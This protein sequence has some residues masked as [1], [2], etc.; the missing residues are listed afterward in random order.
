MNDLRCACGADNRPTATF[1]GGCGARLAATCHVCGRDLPESNRFCDGCGAPRP[2]GLSYTSAHLQDEVLVSRSAIEG[3]RRVLT[4]L[5]ADVAGFSAIAR[6]LG[7][8]AAHTFME[9]CFQTLLPCVHRY[10]GTVNQFTGDGVMALFGAPVAHEDHA[11][12]ALRAALAIRDELSRYDAETQRQ[13]QAPCQ[14]R[15]G[16]NTGV[17]VVGRIGDNVRMD[18][19]A[20]GDTTNLAAR[21]Q[22][23]AP[24][25]AIW[26][27]ESTRRL[28][29][30]Q[31]AWERLAPETVRGQDEPVQAYALVSQHAT[32]PSK[33][34]ETG[35]HGPTPL[36]GRDPEL[37][38]LEAAWAEARLGR[39]RV[40]SV[41]GEAGMGKT[42]L[43]HEFRRKLAAGP[44][45]T[46]CQG[47]CFD[48]G[49]TS[50]YLPF[51]EL[52]KGMFRLHDVR[53]ETEAVRRVSEGVAELGLEAGVTAALL[54]ILS[55]PVSDAGFRALPANL[56]RERTVKALRALV[57]AMAARQ[58]LV[59]V[60]EDLHWIDEA[61]QE[62]VNGL[63][64][65]A[66]GLS[67]LLVL[68]FRP[69]YMNHWE[70]QKHHRRI[71]LSPLPSLTSAEMVRAVLTRSHATWV[72]LAR[73]S[74][75][76]SSE[77]VR[78]L[79][80]AKRVPAALEQLVVQT[81]DGNPL[82][83]EELVLSLL[84][85]G[86]LAGQDDDWVLTTPEGSK[87]PDTLQGL[88][89]ARVD[90][91]DDNLKETLRMASVI[92]RVFS[93]PIL[94][95]AAGAGPELEAALAQLEAL[96]LI[97]RQVDARPGTY[98]FKHALSQE[99]I[100][101][102]ILSSRRKIFHQK[103]G[104]AI[105]SLEADRLNEHCELLAFH[106]ENSTDLD[107][108]VEYLHQANRKAIGVSAMKDAQGYYDRAV[109]LFDL[110]PTDRRNQQRK[111][112][113]VLDQVFVAL[114]LFKYREYHELLKEHAALPEISGDRRTLGAF[115]ARVGWCQWANG[116]FADGIETL[117][118]AAEHCRAAGNDDDL[119]FA[120]MTRAWCELARGEFTATLSTCAEAYRALE[121]KFDLQAYLRTRAAATVA[122]SCL[123]RWNDA[124]AEGARAVQIGEQYGDVGA[125]SFAAMVATWPHAFK[126]DLERAMEMADLALRKAGS[127][128]DE[129]FARGSR[130][131]VQTRIGQPGEAIAALAP[132]VAVIR[133][134]R[135]PEC[136]RF[137]LYYCE[138]LW[139]AG[140][141]TQAREAIRACLEVVEPCGMRYFAAV[142]KR[143]MGEVEM[144]VGG[145]H[146]PSAAD[147]F[148]ASIAAFEAMGAENE[149]ALAWAGYGRLKAKLGD[150]DAA[151]TYATRAL[152]VFQ[153]LGTNVTQDEAVW[154]L[155]ERENPAQRGSSH[156]N[157]P[158]RTAVDS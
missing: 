122:N 50:S 119:G 75:E 45:S 21:L 131:L 135:F 146:L 129:L 76:Q 133:A 91:L 54:N 20:V 157:K 23:L 96:E 57:A 99:A 48:H 72:K 138:A 64:D 9:G 46:L 80:G 88:F 59:L 148:Q 27:A 112:A 29:H 83:I 65:D 98:S 154:L 22:Q 108:A 111:L 90:R 40:V 18:Y 43:L 127:P 15:M 77:M 81:T 52:L 5:F 39:G 87:L 79:L 97:F 35:E 71:S 10:G 149:L 94:S 113:L 78:R 34:E 26:V 132:A 42:R 7:P 24:P 28:D 142:A 73:I 152:H 143:L 101:G 70:S 4:V 25:G 85:S 37:E 105:E 144:A 47:S 95:D 134:M 141:L 124:I 150:L 33:F 41:V 44:T 136:E 6:R 125:T 38:Q 110:I 114:A 151:H 63:V 67:M 92:G 155:A 128:A 62:V 36:V 32:A 58:P 66:Q 130:A 55:Y 51:R 123:G 115:H 120:L 56:V 106:Y 147:H 100:Y 12:R 86:A 1:C 139:R 8:E 153:R 145:E 89:L 126:G 118:R 84:Q 158:G 49:N 14:V 74:P 82:F 19:T 17:V 11:V 30:Q 102:S 13:W 109:K 69:E 121:K 137:S 116:D 93:A 60:I 140:E 53:S 3:E 2:D 31:F 117:N 107:K 68:V 156:G 104:H 61:T 103:V 16:I